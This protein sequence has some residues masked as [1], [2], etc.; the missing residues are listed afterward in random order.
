M[1]ILNKNEAGFAGYEAIV[2]AAV[3]IKDPRE[4][5]TYNLGV[6]KVATSDAASSAG[7]EN[8]PDGPKLN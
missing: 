2:A 4:G 7:F 3:A 5:R 6:I 1:E 8:K